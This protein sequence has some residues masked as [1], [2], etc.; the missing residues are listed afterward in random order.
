MPRTRPVFRARRQVRYSVGKATI[1]MYQNPKCEHYGKTF[2]AWNALAVANLPLHIG[3]AWRLEFILG[4]KSAASSR[5]IWEAAR[6][7]PLGTTISRMAKSW[8]ELEVRLYAQVMYMAHAHHVSYYET[9]HK[10][11][12]YAGNPVPKMAEFPPRSAARCPHPQWHRHQR[13]R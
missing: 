4:P 1:H 12:L 13:H 9:K 5:L 8:S 7:C 11:G 3:E 2:A 10:G 6:N